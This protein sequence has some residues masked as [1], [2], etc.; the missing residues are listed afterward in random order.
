MPKAV[1][2]GRLQWVANA[3][4]LSLTARRRLVRSRTGRSRHDCPKSGMRHIAPGAKI[5][6]RHADFGGLGHERQCAASDCCPKSRRGGPCNWKAAR[7]EGTST[8]D[9]MVPIPT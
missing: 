8:H 3:E 1:T 7:S 9:K 6:G 2:L 5:D 4:M